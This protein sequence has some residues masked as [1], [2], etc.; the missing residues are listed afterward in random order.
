MSLA[1]D[2]LRSRSLLYLLL[3]VAM[4]AA[5]SYWSSSH[6]LQQ[7]AQQYERHNIESDLER[8]ALLLE[9]E[10]RNLLSHVVDYAVWDDTWDY[11]ASAAPGYLEA[12]Y[13]PDY[14]AN[15][16]VDYVLFIDA[17]Q[18]LMQSLDYQGEEEQLHPLQANS[19]L[20]QQTQALLTRYFELS[21]RQGGLLTGWE[22]AH[23]ILFAIHPILDSQSQQAPRGWLVMGQRLTPGRQDNLRQLLKLPIQFTPANQPVQI[24]DDWLFSHQVLPDRYNPEQI[25]LRLEQPPQ[26]SDQL[27][28]WQQLL[29]G[30]SILLS[31]VACGMSAVL[32]DRLVMRRLSQF[33]HLARRRTDEQRASLPRWPVQGNDELDHLAISLNNMVSQIHHAHRDLYDEARHD[34]LTGLG[35]RKYFT[36]V[37][38]RYAGLMQRHPELQVALMMLDLDGFKLIN[39]SLG[40]HQGD[41][42]LI[43]VAQRL[44]AVARTSDVL[45]RLGGDEF[46]FLCLLPEGGGRAEQLAERLLQQIALPINLGAAPLRIS[47][48]IGIAY[49]QTELRAEELIRNADLAMYQA[50]RQR[51]GSSH[52]FD[53]CLHQAISHRLRIE[54]AL[55]QAIKDEELEVWYQPIVDAQTGQ[56]LM[57]E[58]LARWP[59]AEGYCPPTEFIPIAEEA[60][61]IGELGMWI[62]GQAIASLPA[63]R[64]QLPNLTLNINLSVLQLLQEDLVEVLS[65]QADD[66]ALPREA[67]HM[68]L[69]ES[70]FANDHD[71]VK[72]QLERLVAAGFAIHLDDFGTGYSSLA[73]LQEMPVT[74]LKM[75]RC[76]LARLEQGDERIVRAILSL[77]QTLQMAVIIEGVETQAQRQRLLELGGTLMQGY[78]FSPPLPLP[79]LQ[80]WLAGK[81]METSESKL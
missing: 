69:T 30:N 21:P 49:Q 51:K 67:I 55:R 56:P 22:G 3:L 7:S 75:D 14:L 78:L 60:G 25:D 35:N 46:A 45:V 12:N 33:S 29:I 73:R 9:T 18:Q 81:I 64:R 15:L 34:P 26:L 37:L 17:K 43:T 72:R 65:Q 74:T 53:P 63:L 54:Q 47:G 4:A 79:R 80:A 19:A 59:R 66:A 38:Q 70:L 16:S 77:G 68:E 62:A 20:W 52:T 6:L 44:R 31:L 10:Q 71:K 41:A 13:Q 1:P 23:P 39:D 61:L 32:F 36:E 5:L 24:P 48:S 42:L 57:V 40:H 50:K 8:A 76:F 2:S 27:S 58:A 11:M 28:L